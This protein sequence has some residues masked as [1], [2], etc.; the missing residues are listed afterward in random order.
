MNLE[1]K[2]ILDLMLLKQTDDIEVK[3]TESLLSGILRCDNCGSFMRPKW[4][5]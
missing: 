5:E 2:R 3:N 4:G 1:K